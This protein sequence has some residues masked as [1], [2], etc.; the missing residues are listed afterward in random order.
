MYRL[1]TPVDTPGFHRENLLY[2][3]ETLTA[4]QPLDKAFT[5]FFSITSCPA[6]ADTPAACT[7]WHP[8]STLHPTMDASQQPVGQTSR[9]VDIPMFTVT[10]MRGNITPPPHSEIPTVKD[11]LVNFGKDAFVV[12]QSSRDPE[13][14]CAHFFELY[15]LADSLDSP[16]RPPDPDSEAISD[17]ADDATRQ[18]EG[19]QRVESLASRHLLRLK[20]DRRLLSILQELPEVAMRWPAWLFGLSNTV[21]CR[22]LEG[23]DA[24]ERCEHYQYVQVCTHVFAVAFVRKNA[25]SIDAHAC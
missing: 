3:P 25:V 14:A 16:F 24:V 5:L 1:G 9:V 18:Q 10:A 12:S 7:P 22:M 4:W 8:S 11:V 6:A 23:H 20:E 19:A 2:P 13:E 21:V 15:E 17:S